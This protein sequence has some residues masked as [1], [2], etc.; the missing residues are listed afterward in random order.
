VTRACH[1]DVPIG[2]L[3]HLRAFTSGGWLAHHA[4]HALLERAANAEA[5][6]PTGGVGH[7]R[8]VTCA[9]LSLPAPH[10]VDLGRLQAWLQRLVAA[11]HDDLYRLK[12]VLCIRGHDERFVL[13]GIHANVHGVFERPWSPAEERSSCM[14]IIGHG[15]NHAALQAGF[16][17]AAAV[18]V[19]DGGEEGDEGCGACVDSSREV[20]EGSA[21]LQ[22]R[23]ASKP[24]S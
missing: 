18:G 14:V 22:R 13:H 4:P 16:R 6:H 3:L 23:H 1:A 2:E 12:G 9:S 19:S 21:R 5:A 11:H 17:E 10:T 20:Q 24:R 8:S 7:A 15:L